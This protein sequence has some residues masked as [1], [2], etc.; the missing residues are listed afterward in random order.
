MTMAL[1]FVDADL[2]TNNFDPTRDIPNERVIHTSHGRTF[3]LLRRDPYGLVII[4]WDKGPTPE[5]ISGHYTD[6]SKARDALML[7]INNETF[8]KEVPEPIETPTVKYKKVKD[9]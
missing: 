1:K 6:F 2:N 9:A 4:Q 5:K 8:M 7:Y 3:K